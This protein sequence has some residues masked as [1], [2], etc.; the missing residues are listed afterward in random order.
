MRI[1]TTEMSKE[2]IAQMLDEKGAEEAAKTNFIGLLQSCELARYASGI[3]TNVAAD[4]E[5]ATQVVT[6]LDKQL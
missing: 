1:E 5:K 6:Q 3:S 4:Y 2:K